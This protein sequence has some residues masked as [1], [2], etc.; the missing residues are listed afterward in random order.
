MLLRLATGAEIPALEA[1]IRES[2]RALQTGDYTHRQIEG[3]LGTVFGIDRQMVS[4][5]TYFVVECEGEIAACGG[6]SARR[7]P[8]GGD[9]SPEKDD[10][11]LDPAVDNA[12]VRAFFVRP[13]FARRG[14]GTKLFEACRDAAK[15][16]GF[17]KLQLTATLTGVP[18]YEVLGFTAESRFSL[19]LPNGDELPVVLMTKEV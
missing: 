14:I 10:S 3:A 8:F 13:G 18:L 9:H 2:V 4:D 16:R 12:R 5:G 6:W 1:L 15:V 7:T 11:F 19:P 17:K